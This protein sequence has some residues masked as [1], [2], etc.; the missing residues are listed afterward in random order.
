MAENEIIKEIL[1]NLP[2]EKISEANFEAANIVLYTKDK[3][4]FLNNNGIIKKVVDDIKKRIELRPDP[5][6]TMDME[7]AETEIKKIIPEEAGADQI[8]FDPQRSRVVIEAEKPGLAIGKQGSI[9]RDIRSKTLWVPLINRK[10]AIRSKLIETIRAVLYQNSDYRRKFLDKVGHRIYDGWKR[11]KREGWIRISYLGSGRQV[12]RSC[13]FLQTSESRILLDCG[14]DV[15]S[16][17][18][19]YPYL[20]APEFNINELDAVIVSHAH[21]DHSGFVPYLFKYGYRG[22]VY[23]SVDYAEPVII[24]QK[25]TIKKVKIGEIIDDLISK[26]NKIERYG[27]NEYVC[28]SVNSDL[29][30]PAF[31]KQDYKMNFKKVKKVIR[32]KVNEDLFEIK[33]RTGRKI[34]VTGSHSIFVLKK[35]N[36]EPIKVK[37]LFI[38]DYLVAPHK[39]PSI[40][41]YKQLM[42][43]YINPSPEL[44][45][46]L[47]YFTAEGHLEKRSVR[48]TFGLKDEPFVNDFCN[49]VKKVFNINCKA[50]ISQ[51]TR[52]RVSLNSKAIR[53][54]FANVF[55][56]NYSRAKSKYVPEIVFNV[57]DYLKLE[58]LKAYMAG[59]GHVNVKNKTIVANSVS[60]DLISDLAYLCSQ[61]G[62]TYTLFER[63]IPSAKTKEMVYSI[64]INLSDYR[65]EH[66]RLTKNS[67]ELLPL[68][69]TNFGLQWYNRRFQDRR[70]ITKKRLLNLLNEGNIRIL[71]ESSSDQILIAENLSKLAYSDLSFLEV[72]DIKMCKPTNGY[73]YDFS[74]EGDENFIGG[75]APVCL[76]N[77]EP[78]RDVMSLML[79]DYIKVQRSE[80]NEPIFT[81]EEIK[82]M[83]KHTITLEYDEVT[84]ITP[85][86]RITL[87]NA[88]HILGSAM[89]H[90][91]VGNG[92]HNILYS[93]DQKYGKTMLLDP[94]VTVFPRLETLLLESTYGGKEAS[95]P[96]RQKSDEELKE[97]V[98]KTIKR[99][100]KA[101]IPTLG[102]G[103]SQEIMV[104]IENMVRTGAMEKIPIFIDGLIWDVTAIHTA[105]PEYLNNSIRKLIFHKDQ[106]PFLS[107]IF[108]RV[109]SPEERRQVIEEIG[110]CVV[111]AT[112]GMLQGGP[113]VEYL[114]HLADNPKNSMIF[115]N[116]QGEGSLGRR[117]QRGEREYTV[118]AGNGNK[119]E[120]VQ[121]KLEVHTVEG[122]SGH[123]SRMQLLNFVSK[124]EPRPK[125]IIVNH[126]ESSRCLDLASTLHKNFRVETIAP[127]N[128]EVVR[129]K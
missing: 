72:V 66:N 74:V 48:L 96:E 104:V 25:G 13:L 92:L 97:I 45:R 8:I 60:K 100:G 24:K 111:L 12:G 20:E 88:G 82:E 63:K 78:T 35:G 117:N 54:L 79:L 33:M 105:Y 94:A 106:N 76:H 40:G 43:E 5:S 56:K 49:C 15:A 52:L 10:P 59:D 58:F 50:S 126:G 62:F 84:D 65:N 7:K 19:P 2:S 116:Y 114:R 31:S 11:E 32:H 122:F 81:T 127:R 101:L 47:G 64:T 42:P 121:I 115:V 26:S 120:I 73:V 124:C 109:G 4:F 80:A 57:D 75:E 27:Q 38:G 17:Q 113:S 107:D 18:Q 129:I 95:M 53:D 103:R 110:P 9:L 16:D 119:N 34:R 22:P 46:I 28:A 41:N 77:T 91:H 1:K 99:G 118:N 61:L 123:S 39:I 51:I 29:E 36:I 69:E 86:V 23:C 93:G 71:E 125:K 3:D 112:S 87:Y 21:V 85:D 6:I 37:E 30:V 14:V 90:L 108:K 128:L 44:M 89:V 70:H 83:V 102:V 55:F 98:Q 67:C 68:W